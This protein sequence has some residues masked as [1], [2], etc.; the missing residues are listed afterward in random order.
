MPRR[1][2][3]GPASWNLMPPWSGV[4]SAVPA[5]AGVLGLSRCP[6]ALA[7][8]AGQVGW[9]NKIPKLQPLDGAMNSSLIDCMVGRTNPTRKSATISIREGP[10]KF[11]AC[12]RGTNH[13]GSEL[14]RRNEFSD[15]LNSFDPDSSPA[16]LG[17][18]F[19]LGQTALDP[20]VPRATSRCLARSSGSRTML[21]R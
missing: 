13:R 8:D 5:T 16:G 20:G 7:R 1:L 14:R 10:V 19:F 3:K 18:A 2:E 11:F 4:A 9:G 21:R 6:K 15:P 12:T 17:G